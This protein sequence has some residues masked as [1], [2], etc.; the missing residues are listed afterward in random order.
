MDLSRHFRLLAGAALSAALSTSVL[1]DDCQSPVD[2]GEKPVMTDF[3]DYSNFLVAIMNHKAKEEE[4]RRHQKMCPELYQR[5]LEIVDQRETLDSAVQQTAERP[6]FD[7]SRNQSWYN[8]TTSQSFGLPGLP[9]SMMASNAV[10][11]SFN[12]LEDGPI[13][14]QIRAILLALQGP[15]SGLVDGGS[16]IELIARQFQDSL[17]QRLNDVITAFF[18]DNFGNQLAGISFT[19]NGGL[20]LFLSDSGIMKSQALITAQ[21]CLSSCGEFSI[22]INME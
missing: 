12:A 22:T 18:F 21:S 11:T 17:P 1:A 6:P 9:S 4:K 15:T 8:R 14:D 19:D 2:L 10:G 3:A 13:A 5:V 16:A 20:V 7:Y